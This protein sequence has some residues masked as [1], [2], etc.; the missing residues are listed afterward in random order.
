MK[1]KGNSRTMEAWKRQN[2]MDGKEQKIIRNVKEEQKVGGV[3][4][5][6]EIKGHPES[7]V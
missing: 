1:K 5:Q 4:D 6:R 7:S 2:K 3:G